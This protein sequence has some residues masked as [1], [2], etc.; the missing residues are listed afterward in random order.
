MAVIREIFDRVRF[1]L[2]IGTIALYLK[3]GNRTLTAD[4]VCFRAIQH[5][6]LSV[7]TLQLLQA[8]A[9]AFPEPAGTGDLFPLVLSRFC[10]LDED[11][12]V[13]EPFLSLQEG[14]ALLDDH[15]EEVGNFLPAAS[16]SLALLLR[17]LAP[18]LGP[19]R[20]LVK[21]MLPEGTKVFDFFA[22]VATAIDPK[23]VP[24][25]PLPAN[26]GVLVSQ[27]SLNNI[28]L[29]PFLR[30]DETKAAMVFGLV[31]EQPL[32]DFLKK[33]EAHEAYLSY[34]SEAGND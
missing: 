2:T 7:N 23:A 10:R 4:R 29:G 25:I 13:F 27:D 16:D 20:L 1:F 12:V 31:E 17:N 15:P 22:P 34:L 8:L 3:K 9:P 30:Y 32:F 11:E 18:A 33:Y 14:C 6:L 24:A 5:G 21:R 19:N 26:F 28:V